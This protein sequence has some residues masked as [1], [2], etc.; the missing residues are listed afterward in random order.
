LEP[1]EEIG[2]QGRTLE[3]SI[4]KR[5]IQVRGAGTVL[6]FC[7]VK[8]YEKLDVYNLLISCNFHVSVIF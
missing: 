2:D 8:W 1:R 5:G 7:V 4:L 6:L 3:S